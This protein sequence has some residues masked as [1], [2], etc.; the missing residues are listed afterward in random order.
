M[1]FKNLQDIFTILGPDELSG[2]SSEDDKLTSARARKIQKTT[3]QPFH[4][5][6]VFTGTPGKFM[7]L[8]QEKS[9]SAF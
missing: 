4:V 7:P 9:D 3:S 2:S 6:E 8:A 1:D 5:A